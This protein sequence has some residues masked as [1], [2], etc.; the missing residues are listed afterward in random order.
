MISIPVLQTERLTLRAPNISDFDAY[1][2]FYMQERSKFVGGPDSS[3]GESWRGFA[4]M[5]GQWLLRGYGKFV[6]AL[7]N[8][9]AIGHVGP[10]HP[11]EL[12]ECEMGWCLW[13]EE[14]EGN[15]YVAEAMNALRHHKFDNLDWTDCVSYVDADNTASAAVAKRLGAVIVPNAVQPKADETCIVYRHQLPEAIQ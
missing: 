12:P 1:A 6:V 11:I 5:T 8:G 14:F 13:S 10:R 2:A 9:S 3:R 15:G 4:A 7:N